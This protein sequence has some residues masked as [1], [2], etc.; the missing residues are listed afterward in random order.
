L[1]ANTTE[2]PP[3]VSTASIT[4]I[5]ATSATCGGN[6]S[7]QGSVAVTARGVCWSTSPSP[8]IANSH[9]TDGS[10]TGVF[11][12]AITG[13]AE[14]TSY[15]ARAYATNQ[16]GT[17]YGNEVSF[18]TSVMEPVF[19]CDSVFGYSTTGKQYKTT[20][21]R[22]AQEW[23]LIRLLEIWQTNHWVNHLKHIYAYDTFGNELTSLSQN[24]DTSYGTWVNDRKYSSTYDAS[25]NIISWL[26][27]CWN[28]GIGNWTNYSK[29]NFTYDA[30]GNR[31][32]YIRQNWDG[33]IGN[34]VNNWKHSY[35]YDETGIMLSYLNQDWDT[36]I[37]NWVNSRKYV[38]IYDAT[39]N[40]LSYLCQNWD[41]E[42]AT[43]VNG[44]KRTYTYDAS[45]NRLL[46]LRMDWDNN[47][48]SWLNDGKY[49]YQYD[50]V[51]KKIITMYYEWSG[52]W[53]PADGYHSVYMFDYNLFSDGSYYKT[54]LYYS[55]YLS[56]LGDMTDSGNINNN[57]FH[58]TPATG[59]VSVNN[60]LGNNASLKVFNMTGK[61]VKETTLNPGQNNTSV[62]NLP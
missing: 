15:Y 24:W 8:T 29:D 1:Q 45:G 43:W 40:R 52:G 28:T 57:F 35:T 26:I 3:T 36:N 32:S 30:S 21:T 17:A 9:T 60:P 44:W 58:P 51:T 12:S 56:A 13:L 53:I 39:G 4:N 46:E 5:T 16:F 6:V 59:T 34:W 48:S 18:A 62:Q 55:S 42:Y 47:S 50:Y 22:N 25:E 38:F 49:E 11:T 37:G 10:G 19:V 41:A 54:E 14:S 7:D 27:Q 33:E 20:Y 31:I 23:L 61:Q 2:L